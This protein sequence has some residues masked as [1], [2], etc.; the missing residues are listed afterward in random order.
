MNTTTEL[1]PEVKKQLINCLAQMLM[2]KQ[3]EIKTDIKLTYTKDEVHT[4]IMHVMVD[5]IIKVGQTIRA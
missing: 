1:T 2:D 4:F 3:E 5:A